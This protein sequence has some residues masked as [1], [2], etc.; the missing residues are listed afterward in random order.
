VTHKAIRHGI[1]LQ[2]FWWQIE[3]N[4]VR[5][6]G[7]LYEIKKGNLMELPEEW[8]GEIPEH[9]QEMLALYERELIERD[10]QHYGGTPR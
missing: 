8:N 6:Q 4:A 2:D 1:A 5:P 7:S 3:P 10:S 9:A